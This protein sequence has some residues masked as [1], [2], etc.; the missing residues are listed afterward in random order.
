MAVRGR[1]SLLA[2]AAL[3]AAC[4]KSPRDRQR[5][6]AESL[7]PAPIGAQP[8]NSG[9][10]RPLRVRVYADPEYQAQTPRWSDRI[11]AQIER[12]DA[13]IQGEFGVRLEV[14]SIRTWERAERFEGL[15]KALAELAAADPGADVDWVIGFAPALTFASAAHEQ[16]GVGALF[17]RHLVVRGMFSLEETRALET[18]LDKLPSEEREALLRERRLHKETAVLL[19]EWAHTLGAFHEHTPGS[20]MSPMYEPSQSGFSPTTVRLLQAALEQ[21]NARDQAGLAR[22]AAAYRDEVR[23]ATTIWDEATRAEALRAGEQFFGSV[24]VAAEKQGGA[25]EQPAAPGAPREEPAPATAQANRM[26]PEEAQRLEEA[27]RKARARD[28]AGAAALLAPLA[29]RHPG[30][31]RVQA[32]SCSLAQAREPKSA[33]TLAACQA[34]ARLPDAPVEIRMVLAQVLL[35]RHDRAGAMVALARTESALRDA[36]SPPELWRALAQGYERAGSCS[37]A[38]RAAGRARGQ[39]GAKEIAAECARL[40]RLAALPRDAAIAP[41][42]ERDYVEAVLEAQQDVQHGRIDRARAAAKD[43]AVKFPAAPGADVIQCLLH[44]RARAFAAAKA[45]CESAARA[46]PEAFFPRYFLGLIA[47]AERRF[48]EAQT[49]LTRALEL[50]DGTY[51]PWA[52]LASVDESLGETAA[53]EELKARYRKRFGTELRPALWPSG[54]AAWR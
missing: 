1:K 37:A 32:F 5:D 24:R 11:G 41:E 34:A 44:G 4:W 42:H 15:D 40:R 39:P 45:V 36:S 30:D 21:R 49:H 7:R 3:A 17:G 47:G 22:W 6:Y 25:I 10:V 52:S 8:R 38:E 26:S 18:A 35:D 14:E 27:V 33:G 31:A 23:S 19:H 20:L 46:A 43:L 50:N 2:C 16:L 12:A 53:L 54:W 28:P 9:P 29:R 13:A 48:R 51:E